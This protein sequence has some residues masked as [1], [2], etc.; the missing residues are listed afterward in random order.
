MQRGRRIAFD[1]GDVRIGVAMSDPDSILASPLT[2]LA[3][4]DPKLFQQI[5]LL[6]NEHEP[7]AIFVGDPLNLSG[8]S[9]VS[10]QKAAAFAEKLRTEFNVPVTMIDE[11]LSTVSATNAMRQSGVNAKDARSKVDM[12]AAVAIL[13]QG[14]AIEKAKDA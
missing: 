7:I 1:Y 2:T 8:E 5:A 13:E 11:R 14:L 6:F 12:A 10:S 4:G 9:S 3:S